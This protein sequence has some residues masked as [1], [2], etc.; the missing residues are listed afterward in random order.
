MYLGNAG[1][2]AL[3]QLPN[4]VSVPDASAFTRLEGLPPGR[5]GTIATLK[6][7][8]DFVRASL[9]APDQSVRNTALGIFANENIPARSYM[10]EIEALQRFVRDKVRYVKDP[11]G[12]ELVQIPQRTL[13]AG[14]GDC[15]DKATLLAALLMATGK[16]ARFVALGFKGMPFS[17]VLVEVRAGTKWIPL[18]TILAGKPVGWFPPGVTSRYDLNL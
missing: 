1:R 7:M 18:E 9:R 2:S 16:P 14:Q 15:D 12:L 17:H 11:V 10:K 8:R 6:R 4:P 13:E 3:S 5:A